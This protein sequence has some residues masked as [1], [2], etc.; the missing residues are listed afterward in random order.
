MSIQKCAR[1][2]DID[3]IGTTARHLTLFEMLGN[4]SFG[5]YFKDGAIRYAYDFITGPLGI[6]PELLWYVVP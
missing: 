1:T 3:I 5:D 2:V 4:F 6:D